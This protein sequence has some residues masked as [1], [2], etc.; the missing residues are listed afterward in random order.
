MD[1]WQLFGISFFSGFITE[2]EIVTLVGLL[3]MSDQPH[4]ILIRDRH[5][6]PH[7]YLN[8]QS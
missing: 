2:T 6:Y 8:P 1:V 7:W 3:W 4:T 5:P